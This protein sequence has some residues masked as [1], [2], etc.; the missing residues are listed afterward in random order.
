MRIFRYLTSDVLTHTLAVALV[1]FVVVFSG[2]FIRYLAEAAAGDITA[3]ILLPVMLY[4]LPSFFELIL[5]LSLFIGILL[6][7][8]RLYS[9]S[10]MVVLKACGIS[11]QRLGGYILVPA[12]CI[13]CIVGL[14]S[15]S[16]A[17]EG[18]ARARALLETP[19]TADSLQL[20]ASGR[21]KKQR[22]GRLVSYAENIDEQGV[23]QNVFV[24]ERD[25]DDPEMIITLAE[26][27]EI[28]LDSATGRRYLELRNGTRHRGRPGA[29]NYEVVTFMRLGELIPEEE[30]SARSTP[31]TD[32][33]PTAELLRR[34]DPKAR[35]TLWWRVSLPV[36]VPIL[37]FIA[38][39]LS[40]TDAR[41]GR[42]ARIGPAL[43]IFLVYFV[44]LT[45]SR[46]VIEAGGSPVPMLLSHAT[47]AALA[48][49]LIYWEDL[50]SHLRRGK[51]E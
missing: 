44:A 14:L 30:G 45:Q 51:R 36:I 24:A 6:A 43:L 47:F 29:A 28:V 26:S 32:S 46:T 37:A 15:L 33:I 5:P 10:E 4:R 39:A 41:R 23:M 16:L 19:K 17:P 34:D 13:A 48:L 27:G 40:K 22:G 35:G 49:V 12:L 7:F 25:H 21:F 1:L 11:P 20:L 8:G 42:Y 31:R 50:T 2:R 3:D 18:S 9:E 38:V